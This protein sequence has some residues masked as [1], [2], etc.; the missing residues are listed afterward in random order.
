MREITIRLEDDLLEFI[1]RH[2][3]GDRDAYLATLLTQYRRWTIQQEMIHALQ[4][5]TQD[6]DYLAEIA[7]W[8]S[9][10]GDG[11]DAER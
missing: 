2:A 4:V 7:L 3:D 6:P 9:V 5:E 1:D 11:I 10:A 8:D